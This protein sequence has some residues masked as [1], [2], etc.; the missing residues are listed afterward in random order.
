MYVMIN[1]DKY[2]ELDKAPLSWKGRVSG[3]D[4]KNKNTSDEMVYRP[5]KKCGE[6]P[7][8]S[9]GDDYCIARLGNV[10]NACCGHGDKKGYIQ[11][12]NGITVRGYFEIENENLMGKRL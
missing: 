11:F 1:K 9:D 4:Y 8:L 3:V 10:I 7:T 6:Y 2:I 5:C 12:D